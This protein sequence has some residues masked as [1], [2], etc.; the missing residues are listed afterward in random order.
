MA[1]P[2]EPIF[3]GRETYR[4]RRLIDAMRLLPVAGALL[5][6]LPLLGGGATPRSTALGGIYLFVAWFG[7]ILAAA[8]FV[9]ALSRAP[10]GV[11][12]DPLEPEAGPVS[13]ADESR[14]GPGP[15]GR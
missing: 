9:R 2:R 10:D 8:L 1:G 12:S 15:E 5:F 3:L 13:E 4:R 11:G 6:L 14:D 7:L